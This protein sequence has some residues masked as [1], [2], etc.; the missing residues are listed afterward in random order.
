VGYNIK[1]GMIFRPVRTSPFRIGV[2]VHT[3]T[4]YDLKTTN[5]TTLYTTEKL[6]SDLNTDVHATNKPI[7][8]TYEFKLRTPWKVGVSLG[9][10]VGGMLALGATYEYSDYGWTDIR[11][12][13]GE[14]YDAYYGTY[15][16]TSSRDEVMKD[17]IKSTLKGVSTFKVGAEMKI[18][19]NVAVRLGYNYVSPAFSKD[20]FKD[21][22]L[23]SYG[24]YYASA[25]DY[26]NW[27]STNRFTVGAGYTHNKWSFDVAYQYS[28]TNGEF[29]PFMGF[30]PNNTADE[31]L[32]INP[33]IVEVSNKRDQILFTLGYRF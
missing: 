15:Y 11:V 26:T 28:Q 1:L 33:G 3:P 32:E 19:P 27:K 13:D 20:G 5:N 7:G 23:N 10:T 21:S 12:N 29:S 8:E 4:F 30:Y 6:A 18:M 2:Y 25:T 24:S 14:Y 17:H 31:D 9:H 22:S 16:D